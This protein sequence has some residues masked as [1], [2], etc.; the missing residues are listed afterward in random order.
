MLS[1]IAIA[2]VFAFATACTGASS[3]G[4]EPTECPQESTLTY[5]NFGKDVIATNC[6][7]C[8]DTKEAPELT[9]VEAIRKHTADIL[10]EAVYTDSMP[11]DS[12]MPLQQRELLGE[13]LSCGAP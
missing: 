13:W 11:E 1:R 4:I 12:S 2:S 6:L 9:A 5:D 8:H 10:Q 3:T 7:S